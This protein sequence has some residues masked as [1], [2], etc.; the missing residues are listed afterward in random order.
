MQ[1]YD[2]RNKL[3]ET[4]TIDTQQL[5]AEPAA[6]AGMYYASYLVLTYIPLAASLVCLFSPE[7]T[8]F[9]VKHVK[10]K[11]QKEG[12]RFFLCRNSR[13]KNQNGAGTPPLPL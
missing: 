12:D 9:Q 8:A 5:N 10:V 1:K 4:R 11:K 2:I 13:Q 6:G 3:G 7:L